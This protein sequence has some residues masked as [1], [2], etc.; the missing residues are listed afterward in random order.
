MRGAGR[1]SQYS[2]NRTQL[3][4]RSGP[5]CGGF[6]TPHL[7]IG[8]MGIGGL[9]V[10]KPI[11]KRVLKRLRNQGW[12]LREIAAYFNCGIDHISVAIRKYGLP[13][14]GGGRRAKKAAARGVR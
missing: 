3:E 6:G 1:T 2:Q 11:D 13:L 7:T 14:R 8:N 5:K 10:K 4:A 12:K 9:Q